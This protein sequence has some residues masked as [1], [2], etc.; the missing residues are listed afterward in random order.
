MRQTGSRGKLCRVHNPGEI[1]GHATAVTNRAGNADSRLIGLYGILL[2]EFGDNFFQ[3]FIVL[4]G[5]NLFGEKLE[6]RGARFKQRQAGVC[7]SG[8]AC[9]DHSECTFLLRRMR[10]MTRISSAK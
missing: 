3:P 8:I 9:Q 10:S 7:S 1:G 2:Q 4:A 5:I 6:V